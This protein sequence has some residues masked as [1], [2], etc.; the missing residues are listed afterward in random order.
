MRVGIV[1]YSQTGHTLSVAQKLEKTLAA[2][3]HDVEL[4]KIGLAEERKAGDRQFTLSDMPDVGPYEV[5]VFGSAVE[6]FSLSP[7]MSEYLK[8][9]GTLQGKK[10]ACLVT[11]QFPYPWLGGNRAVRQMGALCRSKGATIVGTGVVNWAAS[12]REATTATAI[13]QLVRAMM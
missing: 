1:V 13:D 7:V 2:K 5:V 9:V 12:R 11:Q 6:A 8:Q 3:G 4:K 10:V